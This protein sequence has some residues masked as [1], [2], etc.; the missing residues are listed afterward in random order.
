MELVV[1]TSRHLKAG[2]LA[3]PNPPKN[4]TG[5]AGA[6][7]PATHLPAAAC[8]AAALQRT[9]A[10][11]ESL[12]NISKSPN[13]DDSDGGSQRLSAHVCT[14]SSAAT[15][16]EASFPIGLKQDMGKALDAKNIPPQ[17][18]KT[19]GDAALAGH[20]IGSEEQIQIALEQLENF[21]PYPFL[22]FSA[23]EI[24][25]LHQGASSENEGNGSYLLWRPDPNALECR[26]ILTY[27]IYDS[28]STMPLENQCGAPRD[29]RAQRGFTA[30]VLSFVEPQYAVQHRLVWRVGGVYF[31][32]SFT[33]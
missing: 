29:L 21:D 17:E 24:M 6:T 25:L 4:S 11:R 12:F 16:A 18:N 9:L 20:G 28:D 23:A 33:L 1:L 14:L 13:A 15:G 26:S 7:A 19:Q 5:T 32:K 8:E 2:L 31:S 27:S 10:W 3:P 22:D 30:V